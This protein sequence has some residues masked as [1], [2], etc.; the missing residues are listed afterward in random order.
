[1][2]NSVEVDG[3]PETMRSFERTRGYFRVIASC[4]VHE[5]DRSDITNLD[6]L[7]QLAEYL[8]IAP[9]N[10]HPRDH[11]DAERADADVPEASYF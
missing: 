6:V 10:R 7:A 2:K 5:K 9:E 8:I 1:M 11:V 3:N 4:A